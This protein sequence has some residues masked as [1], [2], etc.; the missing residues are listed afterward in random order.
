MVGGE[1]NKQTTKS[2]MQLSSNLSYKV[3]IH[4][5][6][7][8]WRGQVKY[9]GKANPLPAIPARVINFWLFSKKIQQCLIWYL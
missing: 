2:E 3:M 4:W 8:N 7:L 6:Y 9:V 5:K 1:K